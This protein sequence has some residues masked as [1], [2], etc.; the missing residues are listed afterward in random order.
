MPTVW[1]AEDLANA[2]AAAAMRSWNS[3]RFRHASRVQSNGASAGAERGLDL[4]ADPWR[5][6]AWG[7]YAQ[8]NLI[9][10]LTRTDSYAA[11]QV[12]KPPS[13]RERVIGGAVVMAKT[14][15]LA[16][17][18]NAIIKAKEKGTWDEQGKNV[19]K[20]CHPIVELARQGH[21][22]VITHGNGPQV[23]NLLIKNE[24]AK[25]I[26][27]PMPLDVCVANVQGS[28]GYVICQTLQNFLASAKIIIPVAT[29]ITQV[30]VDPE[31]PAFADPTKFIGPFFTEEQANQLMASNRYMM[32]E[33]SGR[34]WRRVVPSPEPK[35]IVESDTIKRM[36]DAGI[37]VVAAGGGGIPV[38]R[39][40]HGLEGVEAVIDK[41]MAAQLLAREVGADAFVLLTE[42]ERLA[43][44]FG[45]PEQKELSHITVREAREYQAAGHFPPGNMGPKVEA[46]IRF[47]GSASGRQAVI[48]ALDKA[49]LAFTGQSGTL[50]T[51]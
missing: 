48:V 42:V 30:V 45:T 18:G 26:V 46:A 13:N 5:S 33:D 6:W 51:R 3:D 43:I 4:V 2:R 15:V 39:T 21:R 25:D 11:G 14:I 35:E 49:H 38:V 17:G 1:R 22:I 20:I 8:A 40:E 10:R 50:I 41:D 47:A 32:K 44:N 16:L 34:G 31:S 9:S 19:R 29:L 12:S 7:E 23:G 28:L 36:F 37:I 27:P 24:L